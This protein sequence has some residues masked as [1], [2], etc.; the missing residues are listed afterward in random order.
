MSTFSL[1]NIFLMVTMCMVIVWSLYLLTKLT[2]VVMKIEK[3][4]KNGGSDE[5][6]R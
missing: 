2:K 5:S 3:T 4:T 6:S 1:I